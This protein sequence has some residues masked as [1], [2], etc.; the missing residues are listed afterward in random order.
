MPLCGALVKSGDV[1]CIFLFLQEIQGR[2]RTM[3]Q[4]LS[5]DY[6]WHI[7]TS[8]CVADHCITY[9]LSDPKSGKFSDSCDH[10]HNDGCDF[11]SDFVVALDEMEDVIESGQFPS[12][13]VK[14]EILHDFEKSR[15]RAL[16][17]K[18]HILRTVNQEMAKKEI[19]SSLAQDEVLIV[20][21]WAMKFLP[22]FDRE[23]QSDYC[24]K[25]GIN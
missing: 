15:E 20:L 22:W 9:A 10:S 7:S 4:Y 3:K 17:W 19:L 2:L 23:K 1:Q 24:G 21:D 6:R 12:N 8:S 11:C 25:K 5:C 14:A 18:Q 13:E 16:Q